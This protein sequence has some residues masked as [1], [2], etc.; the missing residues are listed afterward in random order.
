MFAVFT[1]RAHFALGADMARE[2]LEA[3][4]RPA[5]RRAR[6]SAASH[7]DRAGSS[8][9]PR[10]T[11]RSRAS[12]A[13][14]RHDAAP[15]ATRSP[16]RRLHRGGRHVRKVGQSLRTGDGTSARFPARRTESTTARC[17]EHRHLTSHQIG[18][19][20]GLPCTAR[21]GCHACHR[22][23][24]APPKGASSSPRPTSANVARRASRERAPP[25]R[26]PSSPGPAGSPP[27]CS[28]MSE[29]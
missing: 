27:G 4:R 7:P 11:C 26:S 23:E 3:D 13:R 6:R 28:V 10:S 2:R 8:R 29:V 25:A 24:A 12:G 15:E 21:A 22:L 17:R 14:R 9:S 19:R 5:R 20:L 1:T 18:D 16:S